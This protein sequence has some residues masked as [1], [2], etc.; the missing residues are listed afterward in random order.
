M[1]KQILLGIDE[2][3]RGPW[4]GPLVVGTVILGPKFERF[5]QADQS[6]TGIISKL[7][8]NPTSEQ[9]IAYLWQHLADS[10]ALSGKQRDRLAPL[11]HKHAAGATTG[12]VSASELDQY[13]LSVSLKLA[14]RRAVKQLL[15]QKTPFTEIIIDGTVNFLVNT[16][17][18]DRVTILKK[19]DATIKEVSAA[20]IIAKV[21][22]DTYMIELS[23]KYPAYG[24]DRHVGYG[25]AVHRSALKQYG[26]CPEHRRSFKPI[27]ELLAKLPQV[28]EQH[29]PSEK[30][31][32]TAKSPL[33]TT[34]KGKQAESS[35]ITYLKSQDHTIIAHNFK[36]KTYEIDIISTLTN[37]I[38]FTEVKYSKSPRLETT[39]LV[40]ITPAKR[41]QMTYAAQA[42]LANHPSYQ[43]YE[44]RLAA[45]AVS[46]TDYQ[47]NSWL[48]ID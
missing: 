29:F 16:P 18:A 42:F 11:I 5:R 37:N 20:A 30:P 17:L 34:A 33:N 41:Q 26:V 48:V 2:V 39:P 35:V 44:P 28:P 8:P 10:K 32:L 12:W 31:P 4:A 38:Y 14:T 9:E 46:G 47:V 40:R 25:T 24:F 23:T 45:A 36:N 19:A 15:A 3:G 21:A 27:Q 1:T 13:G 43:N 6:A 22:R 7:P